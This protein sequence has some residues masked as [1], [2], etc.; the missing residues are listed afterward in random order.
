MAVEH[1]A[2]RGRLAAM[3]RARGIATAL[4]TD[5]VNVRYLTGFTGSNGAV[6]VAA[7]GT[8]VL[9]T[10][11]RYQDQA[12]AEA[13]DVQIEV[14]R[15]LL[16]T[17]SA[18]LGG[19]T[20]VGVETHALSVD[21]HERLVS[22]LD[23]VEVAS[24]RRAVEELRVVKDEVELDALRVAC[25]VSTEALA[26]LLEGPLVGRTERAVARDLE[27]R[28]YEAGA[29]A[30]AFDTIVASGPNSAIPHHDPTERVLETG[31]LLKID[32]GARVDGYHADC[33]RTVVLGRADAWQREIH[34]AVREAQALG[35]EGCREGRQTDE[36]D[37][38][39]RGSL[40]DAGWLE[41][42]TTGLGHGVGLRIHEDPFL[43]SP[44]PA[45][46]DRRTALTVE[47]GIYVPGRGGVRIEDTLVVTD[48]QPELLTVA[49]TEL[50]EL[51]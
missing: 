42:F 28:M 6:G 33:T 4:V 39:V 34:D 5:L 30:I 3:I 45:R 16:G 14:D 17:L 1:D 23:G 27:W 9:V 32:F 49:T 40:A 22:A 13:P 11:G 25:R 31:D 10:D 7:D 37:A 41:H 24:L 20:R 18:R 29:E 35:V 44:S 19:A 43:S 2:R 8:A 15:D 26:G 50:L 36:V 38:D 51:A 21:E 12:R 47:P 48:G 46:L